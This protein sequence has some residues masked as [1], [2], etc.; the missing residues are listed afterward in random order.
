M[1]CAL[2]VCLR[3][4]GATKCLGAYRTELGQPKGVRSSLGRGA[5]ADA[6]VEEALAIIPAVKGSTY[7]LSILNT[8][9][10]EDSSR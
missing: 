6:R 5:R 3:V 10:R 9:D 4:S 2:G 7:A 1:T 8:N